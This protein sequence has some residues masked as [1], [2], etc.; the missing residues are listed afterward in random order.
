MQL[1]LDPRPGT[2]LADR[3]FEAGVEFPCGGESA[4][5][6]CRIRVLAGDIAINPAMR[7]A[8]TAAELRD[9]WR[10]ACHAASHGTVTLEVPQWSAP[11]AILTDQSP[12]PIQPADGLGAVIDLGTT[13]LVVQIVSLATG[14]VLRVET[15]VNPQARHGADVMTR[16]QYDIDHPGELRGL[17]RA[18]LR[19][20]LGRD[21][22][23]HILIAGNT[24]MHHLFAGLDT[25]PLTRAPFHSPSLAAQN[26]S[27]GELDWPGPAGFLPC[28]GGFVGS[29]ILCGIVATSLHQQSHPVALLDIGTNGEVV[30]GGAGEIVCASTAAGPAFEGGR[31]SAGMRAG[32]GAID[33]VHLAP[34][35]NS[36]DCH[37]IGGGPAR[38]ICGSGLVDAVARGRELARIAPNGRL[39]VPFPLAD[40][41]ALTQSDIRELQL[42]KG[43][44]AAGLRL[45][46]PAPIAKL[47]LAGAFGNYIRQASARAIGL[48]PGKVPV[49]PA[50]NTAL[51]GARMLL[52]TPFTREAT[53]ADIRARCRHV[54]LAANPEFQETYAQMM[55]LDPQP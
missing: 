17:I 4:C 50:G 12:V 52:L 30:V 9:G 36:L 47:H 13:T 31:I 35:T 44:L 20:M 18:T 33:A 38:G 46:A 48:L 19:R 29:D 26:I 5:G 49:E 28:L 37:V 42:A 16:L 39:P 27:A 24:A 53:I 55:S 10:L 14:E 2:T 34:G 23:R 7:A 51:R 22:L 43:A 3:L 45:L 15:A 6:A 41:V 54:D 40:G 32:P 1:H 11:T 8:L 25:A 21:P